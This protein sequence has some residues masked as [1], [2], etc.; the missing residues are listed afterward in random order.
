GPAASARPLNTTP[1][2]AAQSTASRRDR[3]MGIL[4]FGWAEAEARGTPLGGARSPGLLSRRVTSLEVADSRT[5]RSPWRA[6]TLV[7]HLGGDAA[8]R[9][10]GRSAHQ[11]CSEHRARR[12]DLGL[13]AASSAST[14][15]GCAR[16]V[17]SARGARHCG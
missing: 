14:E 5:S 3:R 17:R 8:C 2:P 1:S 4:L 9:R 12:A 6:G 16:L 7:G 11:V 10:T 15:T 13:L